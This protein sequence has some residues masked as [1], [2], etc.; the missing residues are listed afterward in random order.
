[1]FRE[2]N[3][4]KTRHIF[5]GSHQNSFLPNRL[6]GNISLLEPSLQAL[7]ALIWLRHTHVS[8]TFNRVLPFMV[9]PYNGAF[10]LFLCVP[11]V[12]KGYP[13]SPL[14]LH[15]GP[16]ETPMPG[17]WHLVILGVY[18]LYYPTTVFFKHF[19]NYFNVI[20]FFVSYLFCFIFE[21]IILR[22]DP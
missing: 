16:T 12:L 2:M 1:M 5:P 22:R 4:G 19:Y 18:M 15:R 6:F 8:I 13:F 11:Q 7:S 21:N 14:F 20:A 9:K 17:T 10:L 3:C